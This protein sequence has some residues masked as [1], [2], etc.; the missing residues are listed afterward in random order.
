MEKAK[1]VVLYIENFKGT[2]VLTCKG[3]DGTTNIPL[4]E[5]PSGALKC[6]C[7]VS[8][9]FSQNDL[10]DIRKTLDDIKLM[11]ESFGIPP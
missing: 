2:L 4:E 7:G 5:V 11:R 8:Y 10:K 3:C 1:K 9:F 6:P